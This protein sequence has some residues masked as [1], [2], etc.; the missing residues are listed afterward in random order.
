MFGM[1]GIP[2]TVVF[3]FLYVGWFIKIRAHIKATQ[4]ETKATQAK[5]KATLAF[6]KVL[7]DYTEVLN[8]YTVAMAPYP[9]GSPQHLAA[10]VDQGLGLSFYALGL[11]R[12]CETAPQDAEEVSASFDDS[13]QK[14]ADSMELYLQK[15]AMRGRA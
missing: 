11:H 2:E 8:R 7:D 14:L 15:A 1:F 6:T 3:L 5:T 9:A 10:L 13:R 4:A 12:Y